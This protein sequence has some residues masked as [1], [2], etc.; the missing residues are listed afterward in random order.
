MVVAITEVEGWRSEE[1]PVAIVAGSTDVNGVMVVV[2]EVVVVEEEVVVVV[3]FVD[4]E[5]VGEMVLVLLDVWGDRM[6]IVL[7]DVWG[8]RMEIV[9]VMLEV[10]VMILVEGRGAEQPARVTVEEVLEVLGAVDVLVEA[11]E[12]VTALL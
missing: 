9:L 4:E 1:A 7:L 11:E 8:D 5:V 6:E 2:R 12:D 3:W 10:M